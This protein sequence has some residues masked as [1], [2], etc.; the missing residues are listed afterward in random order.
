MRI[1][2]YTSDKPGFINRYYMNRLIHEQSHAFLLVSVRREQSFFSNV[3][4]QLLRLMYELRFG[5]PEIRKEDDLLQS[6]FNKETQALPARFK[7]IRVNAVN[8]TES[9]A[10]IREFKPDVIVQLGAGILM[11]NI[12]GIPQFGTINVHHGYAPEVRGQQSTLWALYYGLTDSIG[13]TCHYIDAG[14][15]TG[16]VIDQYLYPYK[17]GDSYVKIQERLIREGY[18]CLINA[19]EKLE[20]GRFAEVAEREVLSCYFSYFKPELYDALKGNNFYKVD[21]ISTYPKKKFLIKK[22]AVFA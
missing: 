19:L 15:D 22:T 14:L 10:V 11:E 5:K 17:Q 21:D 9:E 6:I 20:A 12:F 2:L 18:G 16:A 13:V 7:T 3:K 8:D 4:K 1:V